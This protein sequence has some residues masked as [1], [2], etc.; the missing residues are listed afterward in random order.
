MKKE[1]QSCGTRAAY[2]RHRKNKETPCEVCINANAKYSLFL[3]HLNP[4]NRKKSSIEWYR[5]NKLKRANTNKIWKENN[6]D[7]KNASDLRARHRRRARKLNNGSSFYKEEEVIALY[8]SICHI[9]NKNINLSLPRK[10]S[11][12]GWENGLHID[13]VVPLSRGGSDTLE[14]VRPAHGACNLKKHANPL[15]K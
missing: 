7:K 5:H 13:H 11:M 9:C 15:S 2:R 4:E 10:T 12:E 6:P 1:L 8:G 3:Y 14:N